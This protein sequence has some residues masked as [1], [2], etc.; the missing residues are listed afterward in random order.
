MERVLGSGLRVLLGVVGAAAAGAGLL[1]AA[2][3]L[4][5]LYLGSPLVPTLIASVVAGVAALGGG[6]LI[7]GAFRGRIAVRSPRR[8]HRQPDG[9]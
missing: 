8:D 9:Q 1:V 7:R 6:L 2:T 4:R 3:E 5:Y